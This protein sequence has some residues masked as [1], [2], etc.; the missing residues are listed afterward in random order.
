MNNLI[1]IICCA[2]LIAYPIIIGA[3]IAY[4]VLYLGN[5]IDAEMSMIVYSKM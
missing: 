3:W 4:Q 5:A 2:G 1:T